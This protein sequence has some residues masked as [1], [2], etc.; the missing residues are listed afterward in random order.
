M[1]STSIAVRAA[2]SQVD[3]TFP[4][5]LQGTAWPIPRDHVQLQGL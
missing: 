1:H 4:T 2:Q 5:D 3:F